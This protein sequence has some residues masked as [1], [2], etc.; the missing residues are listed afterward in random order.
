MAQDQ[1]YPDNLFRFDQLNTLFGGEVKSAFG[2]PAWE[3]I[4]GWVRDIASSFLAHIRV[5]WSTQTPITQEAVVV[6]DCM[7][8]DFSRA[9]D[10]G[11]PY[12][13]KLSSIGDTNGSFLGLAAEPAG[14]G[15][16]VRVASGGVVPSSIT[17]LTS[18]ASRMGVTPD[19]ISNKLRAAQ[20]RTEQV[21]GY[22]DV[23]GNV[24]LIPFLG[25]L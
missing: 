9:V 2:G 19:L 5:S 18:L 14:A 10:G 7:A 21:I 17:G 8:M 24:L 12:V 22:S 11:G 3:F 6:G 1:G 4:N 16:R 13:G 23:K 25:S 15:S 20:P